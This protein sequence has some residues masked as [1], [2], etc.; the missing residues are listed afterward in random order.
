MERKRRKC[1]SNYIYVHGKKNI[2]RLKKEETEE[3]RTVY[4]NK[5]KMTQ[6]W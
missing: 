4:Y 1:K 5:C 3:S 6:L 2:E